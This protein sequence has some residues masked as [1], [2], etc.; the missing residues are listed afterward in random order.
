MLNQE[1][2]ESILFLKSK[3][4]RIPTFEAEVTCVKASNTPDFLLP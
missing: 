2:A 4:L 3:F 1:D